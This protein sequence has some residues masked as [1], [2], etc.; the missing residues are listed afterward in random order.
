MEE[1]DWTGVPPDRRPEVRRRIGILE[2]FLSIAKPSPED[3]LRAR[4]EL[5]VSRPM[6]YLLVNAWKRTRR[7][8]D[9]PGA[10]AWRSGP[11]QKARVSGGVE[12]WPDFPQPQPLDQLDWSTVPEERREEIRRRIEI[13]DRYLAITRPTPEDRALAIADMG[14]SKTMFRVLVTS[15]RRTRDPAKM[16]GSQRSSRGRAGR[17]LRPEVDAIVREVISHLGPDAPDKRILDEV[18][19]R[20]SAAALPTP[21]RDTVQH[22]RLQ[23]LVARNAD[24]EDGPR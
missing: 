7:P 19:R 12:P 23:A 21:S 24:G 13:I 10:G 1:F 6:F 11:R 14:V 8:A 18:A 9:L 16:A 5:G 22:R 4:Q 3:R 17:R 2:Q 15:W 20:C